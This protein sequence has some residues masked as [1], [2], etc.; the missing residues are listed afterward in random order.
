M[1][2]S[3]AKKVAEVNA[4]EASA[5]FNLAVKVRSTQNVNINKVLDACSGQQLA[6]IKHYLKHDKSNVAVKLERFGHLTPEVIQLTR[7]RDFLTDT[8]DKACDLIHDGI[9]RECQLEDTSFDMDALKGLV[10][11]K[12]GASSSRMETG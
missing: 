12:I 11:E 9:V 7:L 1:L 10:S 6:D 5:S 8:I 3:E 4:S 2:K